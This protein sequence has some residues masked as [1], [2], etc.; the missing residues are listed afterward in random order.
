MSN[1]LSLDDFKESNI[2]KSYQIDPIFKAKTFSIGSY[3]KSKTH[4]KTAQ[5]WERIKKKDRQKIQ[6]ISVKEIT[7]FEPGTKI[8][9]NGKKGT[10]KKI[11]I[12]AD[13]KQF[14][15]YEIELEDG[16]I[17]SDLHNR[18][19]EI[20]AE[21]S[22]KPTV[23]VKQYTSEHLKN[24]I[25]DSQNQIEQSKI[26]LKNLNEE[27]S[28]Y[29]N[30]PDKEI[31]VKQGMTKKKL[32]EYYEKLKEEVE[33]IIKKY[34]KRIKESN[35]KQE[36][37]QIGIKVEMEHT[38]DKTVAETIALDHLNEIPD[39]YTRLTKMEKDAKKET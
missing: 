18:L 14:T 25:E 27:I 16:R 33:G 34:E 12:K 39:Y 24:I 21:E 19:K 23:K 13:N 17:T 8:E 3:D 32:V 1:Y 2:E 11:A 29:D 36:Q 15:N 5:G 38:D 30:V 26:S 31:Q 10:I 7:L 6:E 37:L 35:V 4:I 22:I 9:F 20:K 28:K